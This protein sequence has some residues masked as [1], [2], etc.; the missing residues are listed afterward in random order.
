MRW[1]DCMWEYEAMRGFELDA[2]GSSQEHHYLERVGQPERM[3]DE[4]PWCWL[5]PG[6]DGIELR[7]LWH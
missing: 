5:D 3:D 1:L 6:N 2:A 7:M 4:E